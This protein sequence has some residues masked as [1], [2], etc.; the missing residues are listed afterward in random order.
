MALALSPA[1]GA[2]TPIS[3]A[4]SA[5]QRAAP[6]IAFS[7]RLGPNIDFPRQIMPQPSLASPGILARMRLAT[8]SR[9]IPLQQFVY[10]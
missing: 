10:R 5:N 6:S 2:R 8:S 1:F 9:P 3:S 4:R 7:S